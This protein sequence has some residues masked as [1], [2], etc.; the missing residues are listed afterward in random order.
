MYPLPRMEKVL[1]TLSGGKVFSKIDLAQAYEQVL[2]DYDSKYTT[3]NTHKGLYVYNR[4]AFGISSAPFIFQ[5][6]M[7]N[8]MKDLKVVVYLDDLLIV[9]KDEQEHLATLCKV[10]Q[11]LQHSE[12]RVK[13]CRCE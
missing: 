4:L 13:K 12:L 2:L 7:E 8:L 5:C 11:R 10:L 9:G 1:S 3:I 6:N